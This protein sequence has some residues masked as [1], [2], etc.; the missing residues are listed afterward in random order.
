MKRRIRNVSI[1]LICS[2]AA[3]IFLL[4]LVFLLPV[5]AA[6][7]HVEESLYEMLEV[8]EDP[9][10]SAERKEIINLKENFTDCLM[11]QNALEKVEGQGPLAHAMNIYHYDLGNESTWL[12]EESLPVFLRR[13]EEGM[14]LREYSR[15]WHGYLVVLKPLLMCMSWVF[16]EKLLLFVQGGLLLAV[17]GA[18][19][20]RRRAGIGL[21]VLYTFLF[22]KPLRI[23]FSLAMSVCWLITLTAVLVLLL[24]F[25]RMETKKR[26]EE[27]FLLVGILTAYMDFLTY[28]VVTLGVPLCVWLV[29]AGERKGWKETL[30]QTFWNCACWAVGY[31]GMWGM[32]WVAADVICRT[33]TLRDAVWSVINRT[34][35]L[36]GYGSV[37]SG[38]ER[39]LAAVLGQYDSPL[40]A[41]GFW[42]LFLAALLSVGCR[43]AK[44][45]SRE[46]GMSAACLAA[47]ALFPVGWLVLTQN[48][49]AIHCI[50]TFRIMG[51]SVMALW[52]M[53][54][55][56]VQGLDRGT[57]IRK[58]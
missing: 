55:C 4:T 45:R 15:Y 57:L 44:G 28:P 19:F 46:W 22:M 11:V 24:G 10:G 39:T 35:P 41:I 49:T 12:T 33:G 37:F 31:V 13:G 50:F 48:H 5:E 54:L 52:C 6:R 36:D 38:V 17:L 40:Y 25:D 14:Y 51:V 42:V 26:H 23:W 21:G 20:Y 7:K 53:V 8:A 30:R 3:G 47:A 1:I 16:V 9:E 34:S 32:K 18:A 2:V 27:F 43:M 29:Q 56:S 58:R